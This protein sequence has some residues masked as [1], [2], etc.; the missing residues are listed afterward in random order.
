MDN[1]MTKGKTS[2]IK[3]KTAETT[4]RL[5]NDKS[6]LEAPKVCPSCEKPRWDKTAR[7]T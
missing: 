3:K 2:Q 1:D 6:Q 7:N 4:A 5:A